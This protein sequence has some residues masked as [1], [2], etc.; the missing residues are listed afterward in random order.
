MSVQTR[1]ELQAS[2]ATIANETA[3]GANTAARV[4]G[5]FDDLADT[6]TL[7]RERGFG[8]LSV[9]SNTNFTP[10][11]NQSVKLT[12]AMD[13]GILSTYNFTLNKTT[14]VITYT[15]IAGAALKVSANLTFSA[16]NQRE[17][18][19]YIAKGGNTI[20]SSKAGITMSH[21]NG[22]AVYFE[23][24]LTA[25]VNDEFTVY[26]KSID[27]SE[28]ITIQSLNFTATTL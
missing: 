27:S 14:S 3:A 20:A 19:W 16:S 13:E 21:N 26:V 15:G 6:S 24:Y 28:A 17:F 23:A 8:S 5:L 12:I 9:A 18:E 22:H 1:S 11:S 2:A 7:N 4:G 10:T 25:A